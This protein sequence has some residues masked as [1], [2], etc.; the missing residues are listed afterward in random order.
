YFAHE[1]ATNHRDPYHF[2]TKARFDQSVS[3]LHHRIPRMRD[4]QVV[5]GLQHL[6]ALVGDGHTFLDTRGLYER[7]PLQV[8]WFGNDLRVVRAAPEYRHAPGMKLVA[9]GSFS[10]REVQRRLQQ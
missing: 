10:I 3:D 8:F 1:I 2:I 9:I 4:Y 5:V 6:A 7:F